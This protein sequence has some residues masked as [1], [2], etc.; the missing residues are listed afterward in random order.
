MEFE[1]MKHL[2]GTLSTMT[3]DQ[4]RNAINY[5]ASTYKRRTLLARMH[6]RF[7]KLRSA[8]ERSALVKGEILL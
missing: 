7:S 5:E 6:S 4:L 2:Y 1:N 8:R 3:E